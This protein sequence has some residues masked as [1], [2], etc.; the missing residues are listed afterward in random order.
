MA[1]LDFDETV[2]RAEAAFEASRVVFHS[3]GREAYHA[4]LAAAQDELQASLA[5]LFDT[6]VPELIWRKAWDDGHSEGYQR[7]AENYRELAELVTEAEHRARG[8]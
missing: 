8:L 7:V 4:H 3:E 2:A 1:A 6:T 5:R